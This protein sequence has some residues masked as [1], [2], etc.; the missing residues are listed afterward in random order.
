MLCMKG[1][2]IHRENGSTTVTIDEIG[3][4]LEEDEMLITEDECDEEEE[5]SEEE[6]NEE[7]EGDEETKENKETEGDEEEEDEEED[8][9][10]EEEESVTSNE[11]KFISL[12]IDNKGNIEFRQG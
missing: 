4:A 10:N 9:D 12:K 2:R 8:I 11:G 6:G 3:L 5:G 7:A 1:V